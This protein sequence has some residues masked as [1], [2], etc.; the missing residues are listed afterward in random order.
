MARSSVI[1]D[2]DNHRAAD[3][4]QL[5]GQLKRRQ[6]R[7]N[8]DSMTSRAGSVIKTSSVDASGLQGATESVDTVRA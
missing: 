8:D 6:D 2:M 5:L 7:V 1:I 3:A 4:P